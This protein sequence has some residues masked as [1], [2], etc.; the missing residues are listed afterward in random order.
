[1][2]AITRALAFLAIVLL[3]TACGVKT[4]Y[5]NADWLVMRWIEDRVTLTDDQESAVRQ[6][7]QEHLDWH[8]SSELADY[9]AFLLAV[10]RDVT[11]DRVTMETLAGYDDRVREFGRR[12]LRQLEPTLI[13]LLAGLNDEQVD[14]LMASFDERNRELAE[15][16]ELTE[17]ERREARVEAVIK[18]MRRFNA[19]PTTEQQQRIEAW[20]AALYPTA[21]AALR[22]RLDWQA[23]FRGALAV[24]S[25][26]AA[27]E[28]AM[29]DLLSTGPAGSDDVRDRRL[30][31]RASTQR[32]I[33][34]L[35]RMGRQRQVERLSDKLSD[36]ANDLE[37]LSC[38]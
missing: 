6:A 21:E 19:R 20:A 34:D 26:R 15:E 30:A 11:S 29:S 35:H 2:Y 14:E 31:N 37:Q 24:R 23:R 25:D 32:M 17:E 3:A 13:D 8:C 27:F 10:D 18:G 9:S 12:L 7:L 1:M 22:R 4:A 28:R 33:V 16:A 38:G 5:N 36:W